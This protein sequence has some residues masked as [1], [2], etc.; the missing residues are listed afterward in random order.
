VLKNR[1]GITRK[2]E[3]DMVEYEALVKAQESYLHRVT[4]ETRITAKYL[5]DMHR[6][7]LG[8]IYDWAGKYRNVEVEK[9]GFRWPPAR[10]LQR[11]MYTLES[12]LLRSNTPCKP[13][14]VNEVAMV[15]AEVHAELLLIHPFRDGN[16]RLARWLAS[17]MALQAGFP[18]PEYRFTGRG[19]TK[20]RERYLSA[21]KRGY[22][23]DYEP[24]ADFFEDTMRRRF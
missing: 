12:G 8:D 6:Y 7:W 24:L 18:T 13:G 17:L 22:L 5:C 16:G 11:H 2:R 20:E 10:L 9:E 3:M 15:M 1:L 19:S 4:P 23:K 14:F 21:V